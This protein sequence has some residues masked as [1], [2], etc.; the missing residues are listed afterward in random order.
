MIKELSVLLRTNSTDSEVLRKRSERARDFAGYVRTLFG[1][2]RIEGA[3][4]D[5]GI[6]PIGFEAFRKYA[7]ARLYRV[8]RLEPLLKKL[9]DTEKTFGTL[10]ESFDDTLRGTV[11]N[12]GYVGFKSVTGYR[13]GLDVGNPSESE[14]RK[15]FSELRKGVYEREWFGPRIK[16][17]RDFLLCRAADL[18]YK[19]G[20]F[21]QIHTGVGDT[22][23]VAA[24]CDP[25]LLKDFLKLESVSKIPVVM[26]HGGFPYT[27]QAAWLANVFP[28]V[29]FELST[30]LP[31]YFLP[32]L[33]KE[34]FRDVLELVPATRIVYGSDA[35][36]IPEIHWMSA[37][38][39]KRALGG[40]LGG[41]VKE[42]VLDLD[43]AYRIGELIL[44]TNAT[45]L[46]G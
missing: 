23:V 25:L 39:A 7:P 37:K 3:V 1:E 33:S 13:T 20:A 2:A 14:A 8:F 6:E 16:P 38:M 30:P 36:E 29:H 44:N 4:L 26:I 9:L 27:S 28:N 21:L 15:A 24:K 22:D 17:V 18:S 35:I 45:K 43:E 10:C 46:L 12:Q 11:R 31:P 32:A 42:E 40:A 5:N 34:R 19:L 41:L